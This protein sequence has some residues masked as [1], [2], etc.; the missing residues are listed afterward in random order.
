MIAPVAPTLILDVV[1]AAFGRLLRQRGVAASPAEVIEVRRV[2]ELIGA[3]DRGVLRAA[4]RASTAKYAHE[5]RGFD[6]AFDALFAETHGTTT[7]EGERR[8]SNAQVAGG[9][10]DQLEVGADQDT[11]KYAEY[12]ERAADVGEMFDTPEA[13]KGFNPHKDDDDFSMV[14]ADNELSVDT[15]GNVGRRG[16]TYTLDLERSGSQAAGELATSTAGVVAGTISWDDPA[17]IMAWFDSYDPRKM[18][19]DNVD[20]G[21]MS[22]TQLDRL[23]AAV[24]AFVQALG[25]VAGGQCDPPEDFAPTATP[26]RHA[27]IERATHEVLRRMRGKPKPRPRERGAGPLDMRRTVRASLRTD[28]IPFH[29]VTRTPVPDRVRLLILADVSLSVRPITAFTLRLAQSMHRRAHRCTVLGFVDSPVDVTTTLLASSGDGALAAVLADARLDLEASSDYGRTFDELLER[30]G[31]VLDKRTA[32]I[33]VGDGRCN[34]QPPGVE[35]LQG[36]RD[37]VHR[38]AWITPEDRRYWAQASCSMTEYETVCDHVVVARDGA[39]LTAQAAQLG[40]ALS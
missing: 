20:P 30:H 26:D 28:G 36:I 33:V 24:E 27:E 3:R 11:G 19:G 13:D 4:L 39:Q 6:A 12:N 22:E 14:S 15:E 8:P 32:V 16:V 10:P 18:Y 29:L 31:D 5:Q 34:G 9:L 23:A 37:R 7:D 1:A 38:L 40:H 35:S 21:P 25:E 17:S 2:L